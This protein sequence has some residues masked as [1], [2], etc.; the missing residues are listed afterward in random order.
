[1]LFVLVAVI[2]VCLATGRI[3]QTCFNRHGLP[4]YNPVSKAFDLWMACPS[5]KDL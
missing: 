5:C 3:C 2:G 4:I 1:M